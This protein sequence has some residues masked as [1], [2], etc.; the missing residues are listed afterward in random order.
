MNIFSAAQALDSIFYIL[1]WQN[2]DDGYARTSSA[3]DFFITSA[4]FTGQKSLL[5]HVR[6]FCR[7]DIQH[8]D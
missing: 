8:G 2:A 7:R 4:T 6:A 5:H 3:P 1:T